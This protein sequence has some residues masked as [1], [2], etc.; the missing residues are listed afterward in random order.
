[1]YQ[2]KCM[3]YCTVSRFSGI[4]EPNPIRQSPSTMFIASFGDS[5]KAG[6]WNQ[7]ALD[8]KLDWTGLDSKMVLIETTVYTVT[9]ATM[10]SHCLCLK[11]PFILFE[12]IKLRD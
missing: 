8:C 4:V 9:K 7:T 1:M 5:V 6:F 10:S 11:F 2:Q 12:A 3:G